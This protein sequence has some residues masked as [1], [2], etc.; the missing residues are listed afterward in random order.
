MDGNINT[1]TGWW[2]SVLLLYA[3]ITYV[4]VNLTR[5]NSISHTRDMQ[6]KDIHRTITLKFIFKKCDRMNVDWN[7]SG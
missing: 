6:D 5:R 2:S 4:F 1:D 3:Y 7:G